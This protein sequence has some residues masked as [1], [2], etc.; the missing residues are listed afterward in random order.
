[1]ASRATLRRHKLSYAKYGYMFILPFFVVYAIFQLYPLIYTF[2]I[3]T[4]RA[5]GKGKDAMEFVGLK[6]FAELVLGSGGRTA[7]S[8]HS[9]FVQTFSNT[10][11]IWIG[12]FIPQIIISLLLAVWFTDNKLKIKGKGFFKVIMYMPNIITAASVATLFLVLFDEAKTG[13]VNSTL[14]SLN[15]IDEP[16]KFIN[17]HWLK[18]ATIC[19][20]QCWMWFGNTTILLISGVLGINPSLFEAA[21]I[22][23]A[24]S[25]QVFFNIT[26]PLLQPI[27]VF[28]VVTSMIGGLQMFDIPYLY[29]VGVVKDPFTKTLACFI[30]ERYSGTLK[31]Y[32]ISAAA[33][34]LLFIV[35]SILGIIIFYLQRD[36]DEIALKKFRKSQA[37]NALKGGLGI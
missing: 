15:F 34:I 17:T 30:F 26:V 25:R 32:G 21:E 3:S 27:F 20:I 11:V 28:T 2:L 6:N 1:M 5:T 12:N 23:G 33:S 14:L 10:L 8:L 19:F 24:N 16:I 7:A 9:A 13:V 31:N 18:R 22:D 36:K 4:Q 29:N 35:T 37:K